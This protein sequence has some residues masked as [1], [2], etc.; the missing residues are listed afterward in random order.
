MLFV[1]LRQG[2]FLRFF[3]AVFVFFVLFHKATAYAHFS[4][5]LSS[6]SPADSFSRHF[7]EEQQLERIERL[8]ALTRGKASPSV[9]E[10]QGTVL[11]GGDTVLLFMTL[12][13]M[14]FII[15]KSAL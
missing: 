8:R 14:G 15:S 13:S 10:D 1:L 9:E 3:L 7:S 2:S 11:R 4:A 12:L 5:P 6:R